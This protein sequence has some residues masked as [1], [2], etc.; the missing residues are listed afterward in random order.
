MT[1][2][3]TAC[4]WKGWAPRSI[5]PP[6][7]PKSDAAFHFCGVEGGS[8]CAGILSGSWSLHRTSLIPAIPFVHD[9]HGRLD[10]KSA[11][12]ARKL[13]RVPIAD[14]L[15]TACAGAGFRKM[16]GSVRAAMPVKGGAHEIRP[17]VRNRNAQAMV[18]G[19]RIRQVLAGD[20]ADS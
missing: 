1:I 5:G 15:R 16:V 8:A 17:D 12:R 18:R 14:P 19:Q 7:A 4:C 6:C 20:G 10:A 11:G 3:N 9:L 2:S 13:P